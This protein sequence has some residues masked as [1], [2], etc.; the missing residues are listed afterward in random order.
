MNTSVFECGS[1][2]RLVET[3]FF[4]VE[5][6]VPEFCPWCGKALSS[7]LG[8]ELDG[9]GLERVIAQGRFLPTSTS[10]T[11]PRSL[12]REASRPVQAHRDS[13]PQT[14]KSLY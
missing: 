1:C 4:N 8:G 14:P 6:F 5:T 11:P 12:E 10:P 3:Q 2:Q 9:Y 7:I 13:V